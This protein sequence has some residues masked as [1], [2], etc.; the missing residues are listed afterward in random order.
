VTASASR[1][2]SVV[3]TGMAGL[4]VA[5]ASAGT[6]FAISGGGYSSDKQGCGKRADSHNREERKQPRG[7]HDVQLSVSDG[8]GHTYAQL[9]TNTNEEGDNVHSGD[10]MVTPDGSGNAKGK[11]NG[12]AVGG[13]F[14]TNWQPVP[15]GQCGVF[16]LLT[17]PIA[18]ATG[19][20]CKLDPTAWK[21]PTTAPTFDKKTKVGKHVAVAPSATGLSVYF[22]ADDGLDSG[23]HDE[24]DGKHGT[25]KEQNGPSDGG[26]I[27]FDWHPTA[28]SAWAPLVL[29][30]VEKGDLNP[31]ATDPVPVA[32]GGFGACADGICFSTQTKRET[33]F[34]GGGKGGKR[35]DVYDYDG[36]QW[37]PYNCS[38]ESV[39]A[40]KQCH[41]K[42]H[43]DE[44]AYWR[45]S[46]RHND[47]EPGFQ[48]YEDPDP[49]GSPAAPVY[50]LPAVYAGTC[51]VTVGGG[52]IKSPDSPMT[53]HSG[54]LEVKPTGC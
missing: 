40:E 30:G 8:H 33:A 36:R 51:G 46:A 39:K 31:F 48:F 18:L 9:G 3:V 24:P 45:R 43:K 35:K 1:R 22:G 25:K 16:D 21:P 13:R 6:A 23:E 15:E 52:E 12:T 2:T 4:A 54:Q 47:V 49:N 19:S 29:S 38:G 20:A 34:R 42:H 32:N 7:C 44:D 27:V 53:N 10:V 5:I 26:S 28:A 41:D 11:S 50:P 37:D 17:Y 14:D